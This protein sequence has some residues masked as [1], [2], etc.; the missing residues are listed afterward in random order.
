MPYGILQKPLA[1]L[2][3]FSK[4]FLPENPIMIHA[5]PVTESRNHWPSSR[6]R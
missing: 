5:K 6:T 4:S 2:N 3:L 1:A